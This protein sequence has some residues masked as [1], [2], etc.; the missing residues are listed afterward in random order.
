MKPTTET[1]KASRGPHLLVILGVFAT[2]LA[3][4]ASSPSQ[5]YQLHAS[6]ERTPVARDPSTGHEITLAIGPVHIPEYLER[7]QMVTRAGDNELKLS[8]FHRWAGSLETDVTRVLTE[9]ISDLLPAGQFSVTR[10]VPYLESQRSTSCRVEVFV[11]RFEGSLGDSV[12][13]SAPWVVFGQRSNVLLKRESV[14][15][16]SVS[17]DSYDALAA[18][19]SRALGKLS[20]DIADGAL[21][22]CETAQT[23]G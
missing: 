11:E 13:L 15:R 22:V 4:C 8:E 16:E 18:A 19:M 3:G 23:G 14:T 17:G 21:S 7:P 9:D 10:W 6:P 1:Q 2:I 20:Q 5:F 12:V